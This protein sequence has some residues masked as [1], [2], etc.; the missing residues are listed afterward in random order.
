MKSKKDL[1]VQEGDPVLR[2]AAKPI[3]KKDIGSRKLS[4]LIAK[5]NRALA[6]ES[7]GV[8]L[9]APQVG[10]SVRMFIVAG[11]AFETDEE[12][13][14]FEEEKEDTPAPPNRVFINP[15]LV[16]LSKKK[17]EMSEGCLSV[18]GKYGT[19]LRHEKATVK[20]LDEHGVP[21]IY[22]ASGLIA[23]IF[24]HECDHLDGVLYIDKT[25]Q[26]EEDEDIRSARKKV[27]EKHGI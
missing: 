14:G 19:V 12:K 24:Q 3:A 4:T 16:R 21:F 9:A 11:K 1:I 17:K 5:M 7:Y 22:H 10:S 18:R 6:Q 13:K 26:L 23:H 27:K 8:A 20:A 25:I 15:E 2:Q